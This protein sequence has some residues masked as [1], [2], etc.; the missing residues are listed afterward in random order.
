MKDINL[1]TQDVIGVAMRVHSA[2]GPGL[3]ENVYELILAGKL[4]EM[5][6]SVDRQV[7]IHIEFE[8]SHFPNAFKI[9]LCV[10]KQLVVEIKSVETMQPVHAKQLLT[11][12]RLMDLPVGLIINFGTVMLRDGIK[13]VVNNF[14]ASANSANSA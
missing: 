4:A 3:F 2:L 6:Y 13:R 1:V 7:P 8:G 10:D 9:D 5:G 11:Y 14:N 12:L